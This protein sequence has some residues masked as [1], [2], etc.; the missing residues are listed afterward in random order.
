MPPVAPSGWPSAIAPPFTLTF[1]GSIAE[2]AHRLQRDGGER[3]VDLDRSMSD[4]V[5]PALARARCVA[6]VG[7]VSM[8]IGSV[9]A[10]AIATDARA[11]PQAVRLRVGRRRE[12]H[13]ARAVHDARGVPGVVHVLDAGHAVA[14]LGAVVEGERAGVLRH[15]RAEALERRRELREGL[16]RG[17]RARVLV[18]VEHDL[19]VAV[20]HGNEAR[21]EAPLLLGQRAAALALRGEGVDLLAGEALDRRDQVGGDAL[22]HHRVLLDQV[23]VAAVDAGAV[24]A[25]RAARHRLDAAADDEVL[26]ARHH[27]E[28]GEV[29]RLLSGAAEAVQRHAGGRVVGPARVQHRHARDARALVAH[30]GHAAGDDVL[31][32]ARVDAGPRHERVQALRQQLLRV[33]ARERP[34]VLLAPAARRA[35]GVHDPGFAHRSLRRRRAAPPEPRRSAH[36]DVDSR[37]H[38][39]SA[40]APRGRRGPGGRAVYQL[41]GALTPT[42]AVA[43]RAPHEGARTS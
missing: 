21:S 36:G 5:M 26:L 39:R 16:E 23:R 2:V 18:A 11:G 41:P 9:A 3:L 17:R 6:G 37:G 35:H 25:H 7:P 34:R 42:P 20:A 1:A 29:H 33:D 27:A 24:G 13:G 30:R 10:V 43:R 12:Q 31:D 8:M 28:R 40:A 32:V 22:R 19:A 14:L 4:I 38:R 15:H